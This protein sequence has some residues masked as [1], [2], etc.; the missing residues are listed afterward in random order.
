[1]AQLNDSTHLAADNSDGNHVTGALVPRDQDLNGYTAIGAPMLAPVWQDQTA[2]GLSITKML[3]SFR[4]RWLLALFMG[5]LLGIPAALATWLIF[6]KQYEVQAMLQFRNLE[7]VQDDSGYLTIEQEKQWRESQL[8]LIRSQQLLTRTLAEPKIA[9][10][11]LIR[12]ESEPISFLQDSIHVYAPKDSDLVFIRMIGEDAR[13][14]VEIVRTLTAKYIEHATLR[15]GEERSRNIARLENNLK[16]N[17]DDL[18]AKNGDRSSLAAQMGSMD[19]NEANNKRQRLQAEIVDVRQQLTRIDDRLWSAQNE[20]AERKAHLESLEKGEYP[21]A[22]LMDEIRNDP[23]LYNM[24]ERIAEA[25]EMFQAAS[26]AAK[27]PTDSAV[28]RYKYR[29]ASLQQEEDQLKSELLESAKAKLQYGPDGGKA[30]LTVAESQVTQLLTEK[31]SRNEEMKLTQKML[32]ELSQDNVDLVMLESAIKGLEDSNTK[33]R[34]QLDKA[35]LELTLPP[36]VQ[37][38][39][40]AEEPEGSTLMYRVILTSFLGLLCFCVG[41]GGVVLLEYTKQRVSTLND[42]GYGGLGIRVLGTV[43]NL[44]RLSRQVAAKNGE[45]AGA[46]SGILAESID[47]VRTMLLSNRRADAPKVIL[48][49]SADEH[50]G[51]TTVASHLAASLAR[52]GRRTLLVDG[53]LRKPAIHMLFDMPLSAGVCEVLRGEAEIDAVVHPAQVEGMW[54]MLAGQCDQQAIASLAKESAAALFRTLRADYEFVVIDSGP[55]LAFADTMLMGSHADAAVMAI[56]RDVSQI[57]KVYEAR[58][59]LEAIGMQVLGG[60]VGGVATNGSRSYALLN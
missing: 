48:V 34:A 19:S 5:L 49:T 21:E 51:K 24:R 22:L 50:E 47:S 37:V 33:T 58:E 60:V 43:P 54:V 13:E 39:E 28:L 8:Y 53:D 30:K 14:M 31:E 16:K 3:H 32:E 38:I 57:P 10:L 35:Y 18:R 2:S 55:A 26:S 40:E 29:L 23:A 44:A 52:A 17:L 59:R 12:G 27:Y 56:L 42:I 25:K 9:N 46:V 20:V 4:R 6:P 15:T 41:V 36:P 1:V 45:A 11:N 7:R